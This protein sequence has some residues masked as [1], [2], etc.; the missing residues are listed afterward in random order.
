[1][2]LRATL[3]AALPVLVALAALAA[4]APPAAFADKQDRARK[5]E[6]RQLEEA[7]PQVYRDWLQQVAP[8]ITEAER[9]T[10][11]R[12]EKDYQRDAFIERFWQVRDPYP[13]TARNE[14]RDSWAE[15]V[16]EAQQTFG[17]LDDE[18]AHLFLLNGPPALRQADTCGILLWPTEVWV[19]PSTPRVREVWVAVFSQR[20][21]LG[22]FRLWL[23]V[24]GLRALFQAPAPGATDNQLLADISEACVRSDAFAGAIASVSLEVG[25]V[26]AQWVPQ[27]SGPIIGD[28]ATYHAARLTRT[29]VP[30]VPIQALTVREVTY[31]PAGNVVRPELGL[32]AG[33]VLH[34]PVALRDKLGGHPRGVRAISLA[35]LLLGHSIFPLSRHG[36][37]LRPFYLGRI[38]AMGPPG[39]RVLS[40]LRRRPHSTKTAV[41]CKGSSLN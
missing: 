27:K 19:Y 40:R 10:F 26:L 20:S 30:A 32:R 4:T 33:E 25:G 9:E 11:L 29:D 18:R 17:S 1:M 38:L 16:A 7:L 34:A 35:L 12:L 23:P 39:A 24:E 21:G 5:A 36:Q 37:P 2:R 22:K 8:L 28:L 15:R 3:R 41:S 13:D 31:D 6:L 14:L